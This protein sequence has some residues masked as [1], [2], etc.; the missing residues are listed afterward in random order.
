MVEELSDTDL[1]VGKIRDYLWRRK[2]HH[3]LRTHRD[4]GAR[5]E[6]HGAAQDEGAQDKTP[7]MHE[8]QPGSNQIYASNGLLQRKRMVG[9]R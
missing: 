8:V 1:R 3:G 9:A 4:G 7:L 5:A 2:Q 6:K